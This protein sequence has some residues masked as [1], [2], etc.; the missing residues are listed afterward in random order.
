MR[1]RYVITQTGKYNNAN[2]GYF[3]YTG[4]YDVRAVEKYRGLQS[5]VGAG[6]DA[7]INFWL[8]IQKFKIGAG[9][10]FG[11]VF[12]F[13][14]YRSFI[15]RENDK[16]LSNIV[17]RYFTPFFAVYPIVAF[18]L[19]DSSSVSVQFACGVPGFI[20]PSVIY[21]GKTASYW[22]SILPTTSEYDDPK[23]H[24]VQLTVGASFQ[25]P[26]LKKNSSK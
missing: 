8:P 20:S 5:Y 17:E 4:A 3:G 7:N 2:M 23:Y 22:L 12:E 24:I 6:I 25:L 9:F 18:Q 14:D 10:Y 16:E 21:N 15:Y 19:K 13:G 1:G 11:G 26:E